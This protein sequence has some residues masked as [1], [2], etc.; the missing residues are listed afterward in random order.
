MWSHDNGNSKHD[1]AANSSM[2]HVSKMSS[3]IQQCGCCQ[4]SNIPEI[5]TNVS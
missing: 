5:V 1:T 3:I 2:L 4:D